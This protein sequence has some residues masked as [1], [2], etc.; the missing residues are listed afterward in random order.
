MS[1]RGFGNIVPIHGQILALIG[2]RLSRGGAELVASGPERVEQ[3]RTGRADLVRTTGQDFG[4]DLARWRD[5]LLPWRR[6]WCGP[7]T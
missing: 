3:M 1:I 5:F 2:W 6:T 4:Y 7:P